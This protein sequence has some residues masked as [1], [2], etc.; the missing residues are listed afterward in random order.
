MNL[1]RAVGIVIFLALAAAAS[2]AATINVFAAASLTDALGE[3]D[4]AYEK[5][6]G[7]KLV[8]NFAASG[9]L[10]RQIEAGAPADIFFAADEAK[11]DGL[12]MNGL[13]V[14]ETRTNL[15]GNALVIISGLDPPT[16]RSPTDLTNAAIEHL[17][18][19]DVKVVPAGTYARAYLE[20]LGLW[21]A[22][23][24]KVVPCE[25]V[26]AALAAVEAGNA[27][28]GMVY[29]TDAAISKK[30]RVAFEVP[31]S[32]GPKI[33]YPLALVK[34][35]RQPVAA[36]KFLKYLAGPEAGSVFARRGFMVLSAGQK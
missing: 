33:R 15:L 21:P 24:P 19:G 18:L 17:A 6:S 14:S 25:T 26:R 8:F 27:Q 31:I 16:V 4:I 5:L 22:L 23:E 12:E 29:K 3:I 32:D 35:G 28:A 30:V 34:D 1:F 9:T 11:A 13:L 2:R 20:K 36:A 7:D 10:A